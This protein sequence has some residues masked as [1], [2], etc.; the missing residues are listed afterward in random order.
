[1]PKATPKSSMSPGELATC[2]D[3]LDGNREF[4][5]DLL[6]SVESICQWHTADDCPETRAGRTCTLCEL[7]S[8]DGLMGAT[9]M[10][11]AS[12]DDAEKHIKAVLSPLSVGEPGR[13][14]LFRNN[15]AKAVFFSIITAGNTLRAQH[16]TWEVRLQTEVATSLSLSGGQHT[17]NTGPG[18]VLL[19]SYSGPTVVAPESN[20]KLTTVSTSSVAETTPSS[21]M[22]L[23]FRR[24]LSSDCPCEANRAS[25]RGA[26][27][28]QVTSK[29]PPSSL[30]SKKTRSSKV[31]AKSGAATQVRDNQTTQTTTTSLE[32]R[33][34]CK[35]SSATDAL[36]KANTSAR[37][38]K[39]ST[40]HDLD[41]PDKRAP[42]APRPE[43]AVPPN[44]TSKTESSPSA[45]ECG[46][47]IVD[48]RVFRLRAQIARSDDTRRALMEWCRAWTTALQLDPRERYGTGPEASLTHESTRNGT[49]ERPS[50]LASSLETV[51]PGKSLSLVRQV[52]EATA[53]SLSH[54][55]DGA[56]TQG[57]QE[58]LKGRWLMARQKRGRARKRRPSGPDI[59]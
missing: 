40:Y 55:D 34:P 27:G 15:L 28:S 16:A 22:F 32:E 54:D 17:T 31:T 39:P 4:A 29:V 13:E 20:P 47:L 33:R 21:N 24:C 58:E 3:F 52:G 35:T 7:C 14:T 12:Y 26:C 36:A 41:G 38:Q 1:M 42:G 23:V 57:E 18:N 59:S 51:E 48:P 37:T 5:I 19:P 8:A 9:Q 10:A 44:P 50:A 25:S 43:E 30:G 56:V 45:P 6:S 11:L 2:E 53:E 49:R 46:T